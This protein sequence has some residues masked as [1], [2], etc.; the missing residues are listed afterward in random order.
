V[1]GLNPVLVFQPRSLLYNTMRINS[2]RIAMM[3]PVTNRC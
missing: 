1:I 2:T 3:P